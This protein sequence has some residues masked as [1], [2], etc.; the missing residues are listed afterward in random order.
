MRLK[1]GGGTEEGMKLGIEGRRGGRKKGN[2]GSHRG[3]DEREKKSI[4]RR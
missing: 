4:R 1:D 2:E 3:M